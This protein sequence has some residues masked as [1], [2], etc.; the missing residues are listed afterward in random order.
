MPRG[1]TRLFEGH[2]L[3]ISM[4]GSPT[5]YRTPLVSTNIKWTYEVTADKFILRISEAPGVIIVFWRSHITNTQCEAVLCRIGR[6][7][8]LSSP[9]CISLSTA[10]VQNRLTS[11]RRRENRRFGGL[12]SR[13]RNPPPYSAYHYFSS[14][15]AYRLQRWACQNRE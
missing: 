1:C 6:C 8:G 5:P 7:S 11:R 13:M 2:F 10:N 14:T 12:S 4:R 15:N 9:K 3:R